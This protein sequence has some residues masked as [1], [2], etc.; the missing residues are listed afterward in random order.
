MPV[1][2]GVV[3]FTYVILPEMLPRVGVRNVDGEADVIIERDLKL[4]VYKS[5]LETQNYKLYVVMDEGYVLM[6]PR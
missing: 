4:G 2:K 1:L 5:L 3:D 6:N